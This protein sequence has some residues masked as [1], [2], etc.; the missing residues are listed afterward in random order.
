MKLLL[1]ECTPKRLKHD[2][3]EHQTQT[4]DDAGLK[5]LKNGDLLA[6][7]SRDFD[8]LLTVDRSIAFQQ[9][10]TSHTMAIV[11]MRARNNSYLELHALVPKT[12]E[13]LNSIRRGD[14]VIVSRERVEQLN[15]NKG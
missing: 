4:V 2:F 13:A 10:L 9:S 1:D 8:A 7:A 15:A 6:I 5:G 3:A 12:L 11:I 14:V